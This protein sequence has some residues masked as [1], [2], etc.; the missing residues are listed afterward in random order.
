MNSPLELHGHNLGVDARDF[1]KSAQETKRSIK[2]TI[3][4]V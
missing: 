1:D 3:F 4:A 2:F